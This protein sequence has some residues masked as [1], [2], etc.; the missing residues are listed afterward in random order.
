MIHFEFSTAQKIIFGSGAIRQVGELAKL[1]GKTCLIV[2][3]KNAPYAEIAERLNNSGLHHHSLFV[4]GEPTLKSVQNGIDYAKSCKVDLIIGV[5]GGSTLDSA[6]AISALLTNEG[7]LT[8]YLEVVGKNQPILN[9]AIPMIAIPTTAGTGTEVT[10]NAVL[11][12]EDKSIK[13]SL[14]SEKMIPKIALID[15]ELTL[16]LTPEV[17]ASTGMDAL[18]QLI[19]P[20]VSLQANPM[21]DLYCREGIRRASNALENAYN[22]PDDLP[23]R[24]EMSYSSLL[25]GMALAN[26][27]LGAVHG[28]AAVLGGIYPIPHGQCCARLLPSVYKNNYLAIMK[29]DPL[30]EK[31]F[32]FEEIAQIVTNDPKASFNDGIGWFQDICNKLNIPH[33]SK[34]GINMTN[35]TE[36]I[37]KVKSA[38]STK[39]NPIQ[40]NDDELIQILEESI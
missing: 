13:V 17:T 7:N 38:S 39:A 25:G 8:D 16:S 14:R 35:S 22:H 19:E 4:K 11:K 23:S 5:G 27:G 32:R 31:I 26:A 21:T 28:F 10:R 9:H 29:R 36:I 12:V 2:S 30:S 3:S 33:L 24:E 40:L 20:F 6:K 15:P 37:K 18:V 34:F 1:N